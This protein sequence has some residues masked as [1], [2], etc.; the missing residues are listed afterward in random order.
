MQTT[1]NAGKQLKATN[2]NSELSSPSEALGCRSW[3]A[4]L[5]AN[6]YGNCHNFLTLRCLRSPVTY[7]AAQFSYLK[8]MKMKIGV[9]LCLWLLTQISLQSGHSS[10]P[11]LLVSNTD[12]SQ[13]ITIFIAA[14][15]IT[16]L[17]LIFRYLIGFK[18]DG[19]LRD[20]PSDNPIDRGFINLFHRCIL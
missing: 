6:Q 8:I 1:R 9:L 19:K 16:L 7:K 15:W 13:V 2:Y 12:S 17:L 10:K 20:S 11:Y 18:E 3:N 4:S 14:S 5:I